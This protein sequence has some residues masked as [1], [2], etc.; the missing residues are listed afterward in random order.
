LNPDIKVRS[1]ISDLL[2]LDVARK[3]NF[4]NKYIRETGYGNRQTGHE[5]ATWGRGQVWVHSRRQVRL[6][7][8]Y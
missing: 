6:R 5:K 8:D 4:A 2:A 7:S 1:W 3:F